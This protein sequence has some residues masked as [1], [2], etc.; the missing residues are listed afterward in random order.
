M[1]NFPLREK[2]N[3]QFRTE[4]FPVFNLVT[5]GTLDATFSSQ[6]FGLSARPSRSIQSEVELLGARNVLPGLSKSPGAAL[7]GRFPDRQ[8]SIGRDVF[9]PLH[10]PAGP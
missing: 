4:F 5:F 7:P 10:D 3:L 6:D 1:K 9:E 2:M 8:D